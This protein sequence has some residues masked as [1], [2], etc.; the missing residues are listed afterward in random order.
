ML[1]GSGK[2]TFCFVTHLIAFKVVKP[3]TSTCWARLISA[4]IS[5]I[6]KQPSSPRISSSDAV[7]TGLMIM[8]GSRFSFTMP[9]SDYEEIRGNPYLICG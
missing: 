2:K 3:F 9:T 1:E 7:I 6:L 8:A 4:N 5:G